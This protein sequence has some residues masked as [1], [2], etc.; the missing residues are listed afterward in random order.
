MNQAPLTALFHMPLHVEGD[1][2]L[3]LAVRCE[4]CGAQL[5]GH[6][7]TGDVTRFEH[8]RPCRVAELVDRWERE[9]WSPDVID[10]YDALIVEF[11][12]ADPKDQEPTS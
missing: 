11:D 6:A 10:A 7:Y 1:S 2:A 4:G 9:G 5:P 12:A 8:V 3:I